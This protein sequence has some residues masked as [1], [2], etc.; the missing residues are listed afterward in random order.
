MERAGKRTPLD[1][2]P[3]EDAE[4]S[5]YLSAFARLSAARQIGMAANP[6]PLSEIALYYQHI[7]P[8]GSLDDFILIIQSLDSLFLT[9]QN[10]KNNG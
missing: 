4:T 8:L 2:K 3:T 7:D 5:D 9:K 10:Q 6:I 1:N